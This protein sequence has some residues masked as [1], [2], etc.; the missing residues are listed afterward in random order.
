MP[1]PVSD[2]VRKRLAM[3]VGAVQAAQHV[4]MALPEQQETIDQIFALAQQHPSSERLSAA[5]R[6]KA[7]I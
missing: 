5:H 7:V 1:T 4:A 6:V 3:P 2:R